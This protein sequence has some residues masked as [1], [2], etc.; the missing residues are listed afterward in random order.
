[1]GLMLDSSVLIAATCLRFGHRIATLNEGE[2]GRI[3]GL[4]LA[5]AR[6]YIKQMEGGSSSANS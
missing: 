6:P 1:M 4:A 3:E 2:F 5:D